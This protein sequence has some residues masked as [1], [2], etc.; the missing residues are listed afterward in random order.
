MV[1]L[2]K[3]VETRPKFLSLFKARY[4]FPLS[5]SSFEDIDSLLGTDCLA[6]ET[7]AGYC[8]RGDTVRG[9]PDGAGA[10][11]DGTGTGYDDFGW[12]ATMSSYNKT[13]RRNYAVYGDGVIRCEVQGLGADGGGAPPASGVPGDFD[14]DREFPG[15]E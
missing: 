5:I 11:L 6:V 3:V 10:T 1:G 9:A 14:V 2:E 13:G 4:A 8:V 7:K 15:C 12:Q